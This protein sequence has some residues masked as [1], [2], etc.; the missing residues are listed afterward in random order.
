MGLDAGKDLSD[1]IA[2]LYLGA[3][4]LFGLFDLLAGYDLT[5]LEL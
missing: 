5:D 2:D 1:L 3:E 4:Q